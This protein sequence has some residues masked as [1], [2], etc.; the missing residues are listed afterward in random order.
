MSRAKIITIEIEHGD[1]GLL[2]AT[3]P[4]VRELFVSRKTVDEIKQAVPVLIK[5]I[6]ENRGEDVSVVE[7]DEDQGLDIPMPWVIL[8]NSCGAAR[9]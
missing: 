6:F 9:C 8:Q 4:Q 5:A 3:S 2:H 7:A 1:A